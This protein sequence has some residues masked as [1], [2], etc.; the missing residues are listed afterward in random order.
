[1]GAELE[2]NQQRVVLQ[3]PP[4]GVFP[5]AGAEAIPKSPRARRRAPESGLGRHGGGCWSRREQRWGRKTDGHGP[6]PG[7]GD[8]GA[9]RTGRRLPGRSS[10]EGL[11]PKEL[12]LETF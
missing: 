1:M 5:E 7:E 11:T 9:P 3:G 2:R 4:E 10:W 8:L 6:G 12:K